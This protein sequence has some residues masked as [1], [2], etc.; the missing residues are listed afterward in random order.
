MSEER[1]PFPECYDRRRL[2]ALYRQIPM[3]DT[4][5]RMLRKYFNAMANLYGI[6]PLSKAWEIVHSQCPRMVTEAEFFAFAKIARHEC[7]DYYILGA[8]EVYTD[9]KRTA[10]SQYEI[11]GVDLFGILGDLYY[12]T[13]EC[14]EGKP[15]YIPEKQELL[16]YADSFYWEAAPAEAKLA[17]YCAK[18]LKMSQDDISTLLLTINDKVRYLN[19]DNRLPNMD[20]FGV[21]F[22]SE[23]QLND[24]WDLF[25][26][27]SNNGRMQCNR[28]HTPMELLEMAPPEERIP[29]AMT[30]GPNIRKAITGGEVDANVFRR[31][32]F[33]M[34]LPSEEL[35]L[36]LLRQ[37]TELEETNH[38]PKI[39]VSRN[40][41]CPCGSGR[42]YKNCCGKT[43]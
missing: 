41:P 3:K 32:I 26:E 11:I 8:H 16:R 4:T 10:F 33:T 40:A 7:E 29:K 18:T 25:R 19:V 42:K 28:G 5:S 31:Q 2:N 13:K 1:I 30:L 35:R 15:Y 38:P 22:A 24:F 21:T 39:S 20:V 6:I 36:D 17:K 43:Q 9:E 12:P 27:I 37:I 23:K 34:D 14:Q